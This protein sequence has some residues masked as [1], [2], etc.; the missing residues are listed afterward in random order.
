M[1]SHKK[2]WQ[3]ILSFN[4]GKIQMFYFYLYQIHVVLFDS[5]I[6][7]TKDYFGEKLI[8][9]IQFKINY[10]STDFYEPL[11]PFFKQALCKR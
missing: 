11:F 3:N 9:S 6:I 8:C 1:L 4:S 5:N 2:P 7:L 10:F